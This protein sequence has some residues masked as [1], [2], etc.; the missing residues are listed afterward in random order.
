MKRFLVSPSTFLIEYGL[1][2]NIGL[3]MYVQTDLISGSNF[4]LFPQ[5]QISKHL[6][7]NVLFLSKGGIRSVRT[8][9]TIKYL[10][11]EN[12]YMVAP[13]SNQ[14]NE[15]YSPISQNLR[16]TDIKNGVIL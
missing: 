1:D 13:G 2:F 4:E 3:D 8:R 6:V 15:R 9:N 14:I 12:P 11:D 10:S 5:F 7:K 16:N